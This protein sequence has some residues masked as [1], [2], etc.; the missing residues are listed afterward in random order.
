MLLHNRAVQNSR[1]AV[2]QLGQNG[3]V[4]LGQMEHHR[5]IIRRF[6]ALNGITD[7]GWISLKVL[8]AVDAEQNIRAGHGIA[9]G[10][11]HILFQLYRQC[12]AVL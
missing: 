7:K 2:G 1:G 10:K 9:A 4:S 6:H 11:C 12:Q 5:V 8:A 3:T